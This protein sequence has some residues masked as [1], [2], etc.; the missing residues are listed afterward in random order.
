MPDGCARVRLLSI[1]INV[2]KE[3]NGVRM[4]RRRELSCGN[5]RDWFTNDVAEILDGERCI[6]SL[7]ASGAPE[8]C[9][10]CGLFRK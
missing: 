2:F 10:C 5:L 7:F 4:R 6:Y 9:G 3:V 8:Y 1:K